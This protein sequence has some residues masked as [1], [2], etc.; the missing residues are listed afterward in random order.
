MVVFQGGLVVNLDL[1]PS[2]DDKF[3]IC[4][5]TESAPSVRRDHRL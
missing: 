1:Q 5:V 3:K 2:S 4:R